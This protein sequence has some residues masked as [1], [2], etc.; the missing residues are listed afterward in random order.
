[1]DLTRRMGGEVMDILGFGPVETPSRVILSEP[2]L[3]LKTYGE[4]ESPGPS[5]LLIPAP[6]KRAYLWDI[7]PEVSVVRRC[8][9]H[10][11]RVHVIQ[12]ESPD[13]EGQQLGLA[14]YG[15]RLLLDCS[16]AIAEES[17]EERL[18]LMGHSLGGTLAAIFA[19][20]HPER[21]RGL[22]LLGAP[23]H[24]GQGVDALSSLVAVSPPACRLTSLL[25][26]VPGSILDVAAF[27][28]APGTFEGARWVDWLASLP[29]AEAWRMHMRVERW[30]MDELPMPRRLFEEVVEWLYRE[31]RLLRGG[32]MLGGRLAAP[33]SVEAPL[34][35]VVDPACS[36]VPP[37]SVLPFHEAVSSSNKRLLWY[38]GDT[39]VA[40]QHVGM[41]VGRN[42]HR[43]LWPEILRW[44]DDHA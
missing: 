22:V 43:Y 12:W 41:L 11:A 40:L 25:G 27:L 35:S 34:L 9:R 31:D 30:T 33:G 13:D 3:T 4:A 7:A 8:L 15:D 17:G 42:A 36:V 14:D 1:M 16:R 29:D 39:G 19:A 32:L 21:V 18:F 28:A 37:Q 5:I 2:A 38:R 44:I 23:V 26:N 24:F 20:L 10:G 6:I